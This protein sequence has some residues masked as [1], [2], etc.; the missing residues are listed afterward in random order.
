MSGTKRKALSKKTR[1]EVFKRD[2]FTC[3]Y[4]GSKAPD[5]VLQADHI[6]PV[7]A[8]GGNE[9]L[10]LITSCD[11]CNSGKGARELADDTVVAKKRDQLAK[12]QERREQIE[13]MA[14]WQAGLIDVEQAAAVEAG[15]LYS[16]LVPG[17]H[18]NETGLAKM[19]S[20]IAKHGFE[21]VMAE[22]RSCAS[23]YIRID[24][25]NRATQESAEITIDTFWRQLRYR[26]MN[27]KDPV[28]SQLR[29]IRGII[30]RRFAYCPE[31]DTLNKLQR[32][33]D[34][35]ISIDELKSLVFSHK[36]WTRWAE[37]LEDWIKDAEAD[38]VVPEGDPQ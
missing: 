24:A 17:W 35:G 26:E 25:Q 27:L 21:V 36:V 4:C 18:L 29:Y 33:Y 31:Q 34:A 15:R 20:A 13:M 30:R 11:T 23:K 16:K 32:G 3:Q 1:F 10:N 6:T 12:L 8:G 19:R 37:N 2:K 38:A 14:E 22:L 28:G 5:V 7:A 9:L